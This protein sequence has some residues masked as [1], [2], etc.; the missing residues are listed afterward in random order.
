LRNA[1][2]GIYAG[3]WDLIFIVEIASFD[4]RVGRVVWI[5]WFRFRD[6][7]AERRFAKRSFLTGVGIFGNVLGFLDQ[8]FKTMEVAVE[9]NC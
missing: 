3:C 6:L 5:V 2:I 9:T 1:F 7:L 4:A 8:S